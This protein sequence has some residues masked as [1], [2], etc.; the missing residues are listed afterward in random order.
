MAKATTSSEEKDQLLDEIRDLT[1]V[2]QRHI[3]FTRQYQEVG[4]HLPQWQNVNELINKGSAEFCQI[5]YSPSIPSSK[6][7]RSMRIPCWKKCSTI[8][9]IMRSGTER[10]SPR[11]RSIPRFPTRVSAI[12]FEDD[13]VGVPDAQKREIFKRGVGKNTGMGLFL[14]A[15]ILAITGITIEE[16]GVYGKGARFVIRVPNGTWRFPRN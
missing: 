8:L 1:R 10:P 9:W 3:T 12:V 5:R 15:E 11:Y 14:T 4:V 2:I 13:G 6:R 16:N 7:P